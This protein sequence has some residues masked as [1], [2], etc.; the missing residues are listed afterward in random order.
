MILKKSGLVRVTAVARSNHD[1]VNSQGVQFRSLKYGQI[2][3]WK[4]D[5]L[6]RT[7]AEAADRPYSYVLVTTKAVPE[8]VNTPKMLA[9]LLSAPYTDKYNQPT[10]FILQ[11][12]LN[13]ETDLYN[14]IKDIGQGEPRIVGTALWI[15][16]NL[17]EPNVIEHGGFDRITIGMY[18]HKDFTTTVNTPQETAILED[19]SGILTSGGSDI[20]I[21]PEI[22][23]MKFSK[24]FWNVAF[25]SFATLTN[26]RLPA[27]FRGPPSGSQSYEP[28][29]SP[30]TADLINTYTIP[31]IR[32]ILMELVSLGRAMG[33]P[34]S[35]DGLPT[36]TIDTVLEGTRAL[37]MTPESSHKPSMLLDVEKDQPIEV[38]VILGE[39]VRLGR[40]FNVELPRVETLYALLLVVENQILRKRTRVE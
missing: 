29:I 9:P 32:A 31:T 33:F 36:S 20:T 17:L 35:P 24:N 19:I 4:P 18:R 28:F 30:T 21:V 12:G 27:M 1:I 37:H 7:V 34:D 2:N 15:G 40:D 13:V 38:E 8:V 10:Y 39:V 16:T 6:C 3:G 25:S 5:R 22:Q 11:N 23:R 26:Y 14:A